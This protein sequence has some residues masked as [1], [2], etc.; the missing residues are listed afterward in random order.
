M[1]AHCSRWFALLVCPG[2][3]HSL[4]SGV[5]W[6]LIWPHAISQMAGPQ[7][8]LVCQHLGAQLIHRLVMVSGNASLSD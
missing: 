6:G 1:A 4:V 5:L 2:L 8:K 7:Y 3:L